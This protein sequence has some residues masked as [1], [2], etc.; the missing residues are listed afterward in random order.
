MPFDVPLVDEQW[1]EL[2]DITDVRSALKAQA[3]LRA[4]L[5]VAELELEQFQAFLV[6]R[7]PRDSS[8]KLV[9]V[10]EQTRIKLDDLLRKVVAI[11]GELDEVDAEVKFND[12]RREAAKIVSYRGRV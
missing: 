3:K 10:D 5:K 9:G 4:Q 12:F 1:S 11:K 2:P 6:Q 7:K 8:V